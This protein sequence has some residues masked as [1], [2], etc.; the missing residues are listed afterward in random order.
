MLAKEGVL[1]FSFTG[2]SRM[3]VDYPQY[4]FF[5]LVLY[6]T[7]ICFF[8]GSGYQYAQEFATKGYGTL[9]IALLGLFILLPR[10]FML[11]YEF[12]HSVLEIPLFD[13]DIFAQSWWQP[14]I[15]DFLLNQLGVL[16][17][18]ALRF[19]YI[20]NNRRREKRL[21]LGPLYYLLYCF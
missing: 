11:T 15:G 5:V 3:K 2:T 8:V 17:I 18:C 19:E 16:A 21:T 7:L 10:W 1:L 9:S 12:P 4:S 6:T 13:P 20:R 14:S